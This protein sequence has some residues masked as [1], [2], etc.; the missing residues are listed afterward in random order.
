MPIDVITENTTVQN[1]TADNQY[2]GCEDVMIVRTE[3][4]NNFSSGYRSNLLEASSF[5]T[6]NDINK[7]ILR[8]TDLSNIPASATITSAT[9]YL[10]QSANSGDTYNVALHR[11]LQ[12]WVESQATW[13]IYSTG[14]SWTTAG[15]D[16]DGN[17]R[18]GTAESS[19]S[20]GTSAAYYGLDCTSLVQD[21]VDGTISSDEGFL[22]EVASPTSTWFKVFQ[23]SR[24]TDGQRPELVVNYTTGGGGTDTLLADDVSSNSEVGSPAVG[25]THGLLNVSVES[26]SELS[27]PA[28]TQTHGLLSVSVEGATELTV[29]AI[30]QTHALLSVSVES[31]T[32]LTLPSASAT[33]T[34]VLTADDVETTSELTAPQIAQVHNVLGEDVQ[35]LTELSSPAI[36]QVHSLLSVS[37]ESSS[38]LTV[39][40]AYEPTED[41]LLAEDIESLTELSVPTLREGLASIVQGDGGWFIFA[42]GRYYTNKT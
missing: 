40:T 22:I 33:S 31:S 13:N 1:A 16:S 42:N 37:V 36:G 28:I 3:A 5:N 20:V 23:S 7:A 24:G 34:D 10:Y 18:V 38:E 17:D 4:T 35:S 12:A 15:A 11:V 19:T 8:F 26:L 9:L 2:S 39:P 25:Q 30:L 14:N 27:S 32:E 21:I 41:V 6:V 29:P